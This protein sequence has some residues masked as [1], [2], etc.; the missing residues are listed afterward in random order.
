MFFTVLFIFLVVAHQGVKFLLRKIK[1]K[2]IILHNLRWFLFFEYL[3]LKLQVKSL[4]MKSFSL[5]IVDFHWKFHQFK[6]YLM[7]EKAKVEMTTKLFDLKFF[8][9][10]KGDDEKKQIIFDNARI[11][12]QYIASQAEYLREV[13]QDQEFEEFKKIGIIHICFNFL[14]RIIII[15][16]TKHIKIAVREIEFVLKEAQKTQEKDMRQSLKVEAQQLEV[17]FNYFNNENYSTSITLNGLKLHVAP[18]ARLQRYQSI[19]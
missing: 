3:Q 13:E 14:L 15:I 7:I 9:M 18:K 16:I 11:L 1:E 12:K 6:F 19:L 10:F 4:A 8:N 5:K 2:G 17:G